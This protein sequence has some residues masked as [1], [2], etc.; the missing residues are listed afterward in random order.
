[1]FSAIRESTAL[2]A[3]IVG[4]DLGRPLRR[5]EVIELGDALAEHQVL[6]F[7]DQDITPSNHRGMGLQFGALMRHPSYPTVEGYPEIIVLNNDR[8]NPSKIDE[9]HVD[10]S[11]TPMP[12]LGSILVGRIMPQSGGDTRFAS[13]AA[14]YDGLPDSMR[15]TLGE[16]TATHSLEHGFRESLAEPGGREQLRDALRLN[17]DVVHPLVRTHPVSGRKMIF[18]SRTFTRHINGLCA[19]DSDD[20]MCW[21]HRHTVQEKY[22]YQFSWGRKSIAFWDNR[23]VIHKPVNNYWP[24]RRRMERVTISDTAAPA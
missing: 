18:Y 24:A 19:K 8:E 7:R 4:L 16:L 3:T 15:R 11:F 9:W 10:M 23:S 13:L 20:L 1:M 21:L 2:G 6:F 22:V 17:P 12:P 14:A 5:E